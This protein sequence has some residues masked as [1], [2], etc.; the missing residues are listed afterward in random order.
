[1]LEGSVWDIEIDASL[2]VRKEEAMAILGR[3]STEKTRT[4]LHTLKEVTTRG[5][6]VTAIG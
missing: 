1:M 3:N 6:A 5:R 2:L 4:T